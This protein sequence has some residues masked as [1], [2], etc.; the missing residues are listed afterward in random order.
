MRDFSAGGHH[1]WTQTCCVRTYNKQG[2]ATFTVSASIDLHNDD[3]QP[4]LKKINILGNRKKIRTIFSYIE[5]NTLESIFGW[6][7]SLV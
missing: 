3:T 7:V 4:S 6:K 5:V 1:S 2:L